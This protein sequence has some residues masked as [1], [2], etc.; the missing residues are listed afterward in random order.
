MN[1]EELQ[2]N[3]QEQ[4]SGKQIS[5][6]QD[7]LHKL[8]QRERRSFDSTIF[9]RDSIEIAVGLALLPIWIW[10]GVRSDLPWTWYLIIPGIL[11]VVGFLIR[12]RIRQRQNQSQPGDSVRKSTERA[13]RQVEHQIRLLRNVFW[14]YLLPIS[15]PMA[16][17]F[18]HIAILDRS[19]WELANKSIFVILLYWGIYE[20]NQRVVRKDLAPRAE[21]LR[22][23]LDSLEDPATKNETPASND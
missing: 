23:F 18:V 7:A 11:F 2:Q 21:E 4:D 15:L 13:L 3:W 5:V 6:D 16:I 22:S 1:F 12:D 9:R 17:F 14:W 20:L 8:V 19:W 10:M